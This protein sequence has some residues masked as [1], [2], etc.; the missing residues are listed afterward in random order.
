MCFSPTVSWIFIS[1]LKQILSTLSPIFLLY[2]W[3]YLVK[4]LPKGSLLCQVRKMLTEISLD[5]NSWD[6]LSSICNFPKLYNARCCPENS[7]AHKTSWR[8]VIDTFQI[9]GESFALVI[10]KLCLSVVSDWHSWFSLRMRMKIMLLSVYKLG[11]SWV[12][13]STL[14]STQCNEFCRYRT[15]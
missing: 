14:S 2:Y 4:I 12:C 11:D 13:C 5:S 15:D 6:P 10:L 9:E 7:V 1:Y 3:Q 8:T